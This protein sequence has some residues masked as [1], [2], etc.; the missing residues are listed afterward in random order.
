M[1]GVVHRVEN[2]RIDLTSSLEIIEETSEF[3]QSANVLFNFMRKLDFLK[4]KLI[5]KAMIPR[6]YEE[7][8]FYIDD[9][10]VDR[11]A[12]PMVCFCDIHLNR[13]K[14]HMG[15]T[16]STSGYG[17]YGIGMSKEWGISSGVQPINYINVS[18]PFFLDFRTAWKNAS[19]KAQVAPDDYIDLSSNFL[20]TSLLYM[21]PINGQMLKTVE[22]KVTQLTKNFHD[23]R[24]WRFIP[25][26]NHVVTELT[27]LIPPDRMKLNANNQICNTYSNG[28]RENERLWLHFE[29]ENIEYLIVDTT[30]DAEELIHCIAE[31]P[32]L[33]MTKYLLISKIIVFTKIEK[34][35]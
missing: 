27:L 6:Y 7:N 17:R 29:Y 33:E 20:L 32:I 28:I 11:I 2:E 3:R 19:E 31:L 13:L 10:K 4:E 21:K 16:D 26:M 34:D 24:E 18:S 14:Y 23:E 35:W 15:S 5:A 25:E 1:K 22:S 9:Q 8:I 30:D 12:F